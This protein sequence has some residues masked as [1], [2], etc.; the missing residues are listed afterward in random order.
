MNFRDRK[1]N[2]HI[3]HPDWYETICLMLYAKAFKNSMNTWIDPFE[4]DKRRRR[5]QQ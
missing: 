1:R 2:L 5:K 4:S 3:I